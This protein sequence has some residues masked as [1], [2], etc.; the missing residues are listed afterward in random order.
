MSMY[1]QR[2]FQKGVVDE[3]RIAVEDA[4]PVA[5]A[6]PVERAEKGGKARRAASVASVGGHILG[7][8]VKLAD[9]HLPQDFGLLHDVRDAP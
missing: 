3:R 7:D 8:D 1:R 2:C 6:K 4:R 5:S 9:A